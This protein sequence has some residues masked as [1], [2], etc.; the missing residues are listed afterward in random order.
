MSEANNVKLNEEQI[1]WLLDHVAYYHDEATI[2]T[3]P[4][5]LYLALEAVRIGGYKT[6]FRNG[7][8]DAVKDLKP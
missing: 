1:E 7:Y 4:N 5:W 3:T 8:R 2:E 6:G